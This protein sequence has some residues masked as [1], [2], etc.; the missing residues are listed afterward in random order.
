VFLHWR[1]GSPEQLAELLRPH[2]DDALALDMI[3]NRGQKVWPDGSPETLITDHWRCR[4]LAPA[5][6][7]TDALSVIDLQRRLAESGL[8]PIK[9]EG[10]FA[11]DGV[12]AFTKGQ[13]Q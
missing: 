1:D 10:L 6:S 13:G 3:S 8:E 12:P 7:T 4:F 9:T 11:L 2:A 5:G